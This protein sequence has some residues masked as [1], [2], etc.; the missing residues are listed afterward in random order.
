MNFVSAPLR[1][2][3]LLVVGC[4]TV[5]FPQDVSGYVLENH[6]WPNGTV[7]TMQM[8]LGAL[9]KTLQD[10]SSSWNVAAA[11]AIDDWNAQM[12]RI[13]LAKV[14]DSTKP[15][16]SGDGINSVSFASTVF[17]DDFGSG[18]LAV[19]YYLYQGGTFQEAD[20]LF[21]KAQ[22][23]DSYRGDLQ[24][25]S[26]GKC[27]CDI[28]RV[29]LHELGHALG[30]NHPDSAGQ[31]LSAVMNSVVSDLSQLSADDQAG[32]Q[33]LYGSPGPT[34]TPS[35]LPSQLVNISTRMRVGVG[36][37]VLIGGFII[38]GN[39]TK[40]V[41]LRALGPSLGANGV[42]GALQDPQI[43]LR[44]GTGAVV[45]S[46][47]N[48]QQG[49]D[50][51]EIVADSIA[52]SDPREAAILALLTPGNYT[53]IVSGVNNATGIGL[54]ES[55]ALDSGST[56]AANISTRGHVGTGDEALIGGFIIGGTT[57]K[58]IL[59]RAIGPSLG[60]ADILAD[61][62]VE[63]YDS[64]GQLVMMNDNWNTSAQQ[65]EII[66]TGI[67]PSDTRESALIAAL[68]P[69]NYTAVVRGA[70]GGVGLGLVEIYDLSP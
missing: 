54:V 14:M 7:V 12:A 3:P 32:I 25:D 1:S 42:T 2:L 20:V 15:V 59:V 39:Q 23:F 62:L 46:N 52:P 57:S 5:F 40:K 8:E 66:A 27:I 30:L 34:P 38:Q 64:G 36:N 16:S 68:A 55:Y 35:P 22:T 28:Q 17:G 19:T 49:A 4:W 21:N 63:V 47:D 53:V 50:A 48:W 33:F 31:H 24:F 10:G 18:V 37:D 70:D 51:A 61:P 56:R 60:G 69:G 26:Q 13:Q 65:S 58:N 6:S 43:E 9:N 41:V 44:D 11:P 67:P 45:D 29:F